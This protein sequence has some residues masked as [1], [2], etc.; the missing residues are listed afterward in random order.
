MRE[1][2]FTFG[3]GNGLV[4]IL[5]EPNP[6]V[7]RPN[8]P[9]V[10]ASN[11]GMNHRVG[12]FRAYV[13]LARRLAGF[14]YS[15]LRFDLAGMGD[16]EPR[17]DDRSEFE[18]ALMDVRDAANA[19]SQ[20]KGATRFVQLG[21]CSG[22]DSAHTI[23]VEDPRVV[24]SVF[25]EGY[26][27][28]TPKFYL[29]RYVKRP[30]S[31]KFWMTYAKRKLERFIPSTTNGVREAGAAVEIYVREYPTRERLFADLRVLSSRG[32]KMLFVYCGGAEHAYNYA[33]QFYD[34]F[35]EFVG[36]PHI[37]VEY[38][39]KADHVYSSIAQRAALLDRITRW[40]QTH[41]P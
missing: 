34:I 35:P 6:G 17:K 9:V 13:D 40:M 4:G 32:V 12:P 25:L 31:A 7:A 20:R 38:F 37:E 2:V 22:V 23:S 41:F 3:P 5:T 19:L 36:D 27:Y 16:S 15:M 30:A 26:S 14:G 39:A 29:Y 1:S 33:G 21:L 11:V 10:I 18:R 28:P 8:A 24:A